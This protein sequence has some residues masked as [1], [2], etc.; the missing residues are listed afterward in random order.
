MYMAFACAALHVLYIIV[1]SLSFRVFCRCLSCD[2]EME[3][4][5]RNY[6]LMHYMMASKVFPE[7]TP[8]EDTL[9]LYTRVRT[10]TCALALKIIFEIRVHVHNYVHDTHFVIARIT[11][12][13]YFESCTP[14]L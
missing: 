2:S 12:F 5:Y 11:H 8:I 14:L 9:K 10:C 1:D 6:A 4:A 13:T 7:G 3:T